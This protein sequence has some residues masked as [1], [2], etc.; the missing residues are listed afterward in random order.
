MGE[1]YYKIFYLPN[2]SIRW[3]NVNGFIDTIGSLDNILI[4]TVETKETGD[5]DLPIDYNYNINEINGSESER[6]Y[7]IEKLK[8]CNRKHNIKYLLGEE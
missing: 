5:C 7:I 2:G 4:D 3:V 6:Y 8:G 1:F